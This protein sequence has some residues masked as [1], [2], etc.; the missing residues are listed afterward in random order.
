MANSDKPNGFTLVK[1]VFGEHARMKFPVAASQ[2][3][4][5]GDAIILVAGLIQIGLATSGAILGVAAHPITTTASP[6]RADDQMLVELA[7]PGNIF[8]G[9]LSGSSVAATLGSECDI[10]GTTGIMELNEDASVEDVAQ[11][12]RLVSDVRDDLEQGLNDRVQFIWKRSQF[13]GIL[14]A[15]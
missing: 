8:E 12:V 7:L 1:S 5:A 13:S 9:Q 14:A 11:I 10:E 3:I 4:A 15:I 6:T 2:T